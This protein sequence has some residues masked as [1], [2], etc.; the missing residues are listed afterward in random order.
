MLMLLFAIDFVSRT[1]NIFFSSSINELNQ[2]SQMDSSV[3]Q[4]F[5][6]PFFSFDFSSIHIKL[7]QYSI[8]LYMV[9]DKW[10]YEY[11]SQTYAAMFNTLPLIYE[12]ICSIWASLI[13]IKVQSSNIP[14]RISSIYAQYY[15]VNGV[16]YIYNRET[17]ESSRTL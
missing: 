17:S 13:T 9:Y 7:L 16:H 5:S 8:Q 12:D 1:N 2:H 15:Y 10:I 11:E 3:I 4:L 14:L 6:I